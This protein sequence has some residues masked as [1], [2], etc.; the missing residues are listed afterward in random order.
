MVE[1]LKEVSKHMP[2]KSH[3]TFMTAA[4]LLVSCKAAITDSEPEDTTPKVHLSIE[5]VGVETSKAVVNGNAF[6]DEDEC[7][8]GLFLTSESGGIYEGGPYS[9]M[10]FVKEEKSQKWTCSTPVVLTDAPG[11]LYAYYPYSSSVSNLS[12][13]PV[14]SSLDGKDYMYA[15]PVSGVNASNSEVTLEMKHALALI[16][17]NLS[18]GTGYE[19]GCK[20][21]SV[22]LSGEGIAATGTMDAS[23]GNISAEASE[24][25]V[26]GIEH[27]FSEG[28]SENLLVV[29]AVVSSEKQ[30]VKVACTIDG[31][32]KELTFESSK[33]L[34]IKQG[35]RFSVNI[36]VSGTGLKIN[37]ISITDW[38]GGSVVETELVKEGIVITGADS[39]QYGGELEF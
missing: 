11:N 35:V 1:V 24:F 4:L 9:N 14:Q 17:L 29:P 28:L 38:N 22:A 18:K 8:I 27:S 32:H 20:M 26:S 23:T 10:E 13:V 16:C 34:I 7:S 12:E 15:I 30:K 19:G 36:T 39:V 3:I 25:L 33:G 5:A 6:P 31:E 37:G 2:I 21:T